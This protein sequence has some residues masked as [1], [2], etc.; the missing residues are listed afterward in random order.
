MAW[1]LRRSFLRFLVGRVS[2]VQFPY[3]ILSLDV[4][5]ICFLYDTVFSTSSVYFQYIKEIYIAYL[6]YYSAEKELLTIERMRNMNDE[7][8]RV[9][10][11]LNPKQVTNKA[12]KGKYKFLQKYY[13]RYVFTSYLHVD[14][15][16]TGQLEY[17]E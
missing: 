8:R 13:H 2:W 5:C 14:K 17:F 6:L 4:L 16:I 3:V 10:L 7:E 1:W 9:E 11:R 15:S 12:V